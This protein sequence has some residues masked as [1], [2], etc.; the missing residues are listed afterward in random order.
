M[1]QAPSGMSEVSIRRRGRD[2]WIVERRPPRMFAFAARGGVNLCHAGGAVVLTFRPVFPL[3]PL[4]YMLAYLP[5]RRAS[6]WLRGASVRRRASP[7]W[8]LWRSA[9]PESSA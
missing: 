6:S 8:C 5:G 1:A 9:V 7:S 4:P 2:R 3:S